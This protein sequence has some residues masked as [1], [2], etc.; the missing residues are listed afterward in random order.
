M[1]TSDLLEFILDGNLSFDQ[2]KHLVSNQRDVIL[3][4]DTSMA[5]SFMSILQD[6]SA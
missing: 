4:L 5:D 2:V 6:V 1:E 3:K